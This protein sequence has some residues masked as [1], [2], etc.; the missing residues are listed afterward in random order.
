M[1][2]RHS[3]A[4]RQRGLIYLRIT[5]VEGA[6]HVVVFLMSDFLAGL[7]PNSRGILQL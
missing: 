7:T 3:T 4:I 5:K 2:R 6:T 1:P